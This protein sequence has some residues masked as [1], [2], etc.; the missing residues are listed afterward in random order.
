MDFSAANTSLWGMVIQFGIIAA[1]LLLANF[2]R[3]QVPFVRKTLMPTAVL[4][5]FLLLILRLI[6]P[7]LINTD[8]LEMIT[9]HGI[10]LG[11]IALSLRVPEK[12]V[13]TDKG[14]LT[15][16]KTGALIVSCYLMQGIL[17]MVISLGLAYTFM[18]GLFK[19]AGL[20]LPMGYGQGPGQANNVG[21][22]YQNLGFVGGQ[23]FG[24]SI[25]AAGFLS[26]CVVGVIYLNVMQRKGKLK[27]TDVDEQQSGSVTVETFQDKGEIPISESV[28]RLSVQIALVV[29]VYLLTY[30]LIWG[31]TS[32]VA[33][34]SEGLSNMVSSLLW[35]FNFI[36]GSVL[37]MLARVLF[38]NLRKANV[39]KRQY[40]NNYLLSRI[41]GFAFDLMIIAGVGT[42]NIS[43]IK[44]LWLP[45]VLMAVTGAIFTLV[46]LQWLCKKVYPGYYQEGLLS[47]YGMM[48]GTIGSGVLLLRE[49]DPYFKTPAANNLVTGSSVAVI[50]GAPMLALIGIAPSQPWL[51]VAL[52]AIYL[53]GLVIFMLKAK[54]GK[55]K[56]G[57]TQ[58]AAEQSK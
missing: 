17:G 42:I 20:L 1:I 18:P 24:L 49:V 38:K 55:D 29:V 58:K 48:T 46:W 50:F 26:A 11:F 43:D 3:R 7:N 47:M 56:K 35:G 40:Q 14:N 39:M 44:E 10:G 23:S 28:D 45:F 13:Q 8:V 22:T 36:F 31:I 54:G 34:L 41:S 15:G 5:G 16:P 21:T 12:S 53:V 9:Y 52:M 33:T 57:K 19:A 4:G 37:A 32:G 51:T 25:A 30:L 27:I 6:F 2:L